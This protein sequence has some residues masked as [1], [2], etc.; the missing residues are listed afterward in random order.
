MPW[1]I[2]DCQHFYGLHNHSKANSLNYQIIYNT[3]L[4]KRR[5]Y[6]PVYSLAI[7]SFSKLPGY[8]P[9]KVHHLL[10]LLVRQLTHLTHQRLYFWLSLSGCQD[11]AALHHLHIHFRSGAEPGFIEPQAFHDKRR[12]TGVISKPRRITHGKYA[13]GRFKYF[14]LQ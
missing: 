14:W 5:H 9:N 1:S 10:L 8:H 11:H 6:A 7:S 2:Y 4:T 12:D 3:G 13:V